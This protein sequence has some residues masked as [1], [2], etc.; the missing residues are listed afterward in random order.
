MN[1]YSIRFIHWLFRVRNDTV[2][3]RNSWDIYFKG[4]STNNFLITILF[5]L[6]LLLYRSLTF[7]LKQ[8]ARCKSST[9]SDRCRRSRM[10]LAEPPEVLSQ[11]SLSH[12]GLQVT[13]MPVL[14][15]CP[16]EEAEPQLRVCAGGWKQLQFEY[17]HKSIFISA[18]VCS[19][20]CT[21]T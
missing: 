10:L 18:S 7:F 9:R 1:S 14:T 2:K 15:C 19:R 21:H 11:W 20:T 4:Y 8:T 13:Q 17:A 5:L 6:R 16:R 12:V 3:H